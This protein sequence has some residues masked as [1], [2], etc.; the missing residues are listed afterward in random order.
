MNYWRQTTHIMS[1]FKEEN[2]RGDKRLPN[3]FMTGFL[4][5][6]SHERLKFRAY[7]SNSVLGTQLDCGAGADPCLYVNNNQNLQ[8]KPPLAF[9]PRNAETPV[10]MLPFSLS[11]MRRLWRAFAH[12][13]V[14]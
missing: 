3:N 12:Q 1:Y 8:S 5:V 11:C 6:G 2:F 4:E 13:L 14:P 9:L 10:K 7:V